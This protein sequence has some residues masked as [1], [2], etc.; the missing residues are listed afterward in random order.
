MCCKVLLSGFDSD[1]KL[2]VIK[3]WHI[4]VPAIAVIQKGQTL[5]VFIRRKEWVDGYMLWKWI[6][7]YSFLNVFENITWVIIVI[8]EFLK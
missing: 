4:S 3:S 6:F 8:V 7:R 2:E 5:F 1:V